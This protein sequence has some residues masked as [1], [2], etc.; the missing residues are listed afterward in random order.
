LSARGSTGNPSTRSAMMLR[1][2]SDVPPSIELP[3]ARR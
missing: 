3:F 1:R 2:I